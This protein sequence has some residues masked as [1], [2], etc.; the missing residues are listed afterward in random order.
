MAQRLMDVV[1]LWREEGVGGMSHL[2]SSI[3]HLQSQCIQEGSLFQDPNSRSQPPASLSL[4]VLRVF[5][6]LRDLLVQV[7]SLLNLL[8]AY[9]KF[10]ASM[11]LPD[12]KEG[13]DAF[14]VCLLVSCFIGELL[15][16][17]LED[18][19]GGGLF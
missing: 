13:L 14:L 8:L 19:V 17:I 3:K 11:F 7:E 18:T 12:R 15:N 9:Q 16:F 4:D 5:S 2:N 6:E 10:R 1:W